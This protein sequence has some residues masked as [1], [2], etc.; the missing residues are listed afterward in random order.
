MGSCASSSIGTSATY[1]GTGVGAYDGVFHDN[2]EAE[3]LHYV[4]NDALIF[5]G[6]LAV[7]EA[8]SANTQYYWNI[9]NLL[10]DP[11]LDFYRALPTQLLASHDAE[12]TVGT[13]Y[14]EVTVTEQDGA[15]AVPGARVAIWHASA[16]GLYSGY[17]PNSFQSVETRG[18]NYCRGVQIADAS[19]RVTFDTVFPGWYVVRTPHIHVKV[20]I[21]GTPVLTTQ[22]YFDEPINS[23]VFDLV[24]PYT[25]RGNRPVR[26]QNDG[27][28]DPRLVVATTAHPGA[29]SSDFTIC[30]R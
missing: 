23:E 11:E 18:R 6:N 4:T 10:G 7:Q 29:F 5:A 21:Q 30:V 19:G 1:A 13:S 3:D 27:L 25:R 20:L 28:F 16:E 9:Y 8:G 14:L 24:E 12:A 26:N 2:G 17:A 15:T 22:L